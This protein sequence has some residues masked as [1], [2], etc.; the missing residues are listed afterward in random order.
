MMKFTFNDSM[1]L[2]LALQQLN[3]S[4]SDFQKKMYSQLHLNNTQFIEKT[5]TK[6][7]KLHPDGVTPLHT[8]ELLYASKTHLI[9]TTQYGR[10]KN[11]QSRPNQKP[12]TQHTKIKAHQKPYS[13]SV[14][15]PIVTIK[16][17]KRRIEK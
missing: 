1:L 10:I 7:D 4:R 17:A 5:T 3:I 11:V 2:T 14:N 12:Q 13:K 15:K 8:H 16:S 9:K 6:L